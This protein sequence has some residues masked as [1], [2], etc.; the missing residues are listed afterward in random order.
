MGSIPL[1]ISKER[2]LYISIPLNTCKHLQSFPYKH[3]W[4]PMCLISDCLTETVCEGPSIPNPFQSRH[5]L[6]LKPT[7]L[8]KT[9]CHTFC[10]CLSIIV[11]VEFFILEL[12]RPSH[13]EPPRCRPN[14]RQ[15]KPNSY[16]PHKLSFQ[17]SSKLRRCHLG[18]RDSVR[19]RS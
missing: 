5:T 12:A 17:H 13:S 3:N 16:V 4:Y 11:S 1:S 19:N 14:K 18:S 10:H 9:C 2:S 8:F 6:Q 7:F 15:S